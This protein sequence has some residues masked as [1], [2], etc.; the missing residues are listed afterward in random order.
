ME[1][2]LKAELADHLGYP[3]GDSKKKKTANTRNG[4]YLKSVKTTAGKLE[5]DI[6]RDRKG[7]FNP[8]VVPKYEGVS[9]KL[10][11]QIISMYSKGMTTRDIE[12]RIKEIYFGL[13]ISSTA[14]SSITHIRKSEWDDITHIFVTHGDPDHYWHFDQVAN[15]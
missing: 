8:K 13:E 15:A 11:E 9:S 6:P 3:H 12:S 2:M 10:E 4:S 7:T 1:T 5:L 14:V